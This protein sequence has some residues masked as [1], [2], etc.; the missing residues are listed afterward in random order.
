M[1]FSKKY[2]LLIVIFLFFV[3]NFAFLLIPANQAEAGSL[4]ESQTGK[5]EI[6]SAFGENDEEPNDVRLIIAKIINIFLGLLAMIFIVMLVWAGYKWMTSSGNEE[7]VK[8]AK[9][10]IRTAV[11]GL[12]II[13]MAYSITY[14]V[15]RAMVDVTLGEWV[16]LH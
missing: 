7:K 16:T 14:F 5:K 9:D 1:K 13:F 4:W 6:G 11:V 12:I 15:F 2:F 3:L 8:E 10:Q